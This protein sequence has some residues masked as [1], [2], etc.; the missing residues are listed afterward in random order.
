MTLVLSAG[1]AAIEV[2]CIIDPAEGGG[3]CAGLPVVAVLPRRSFMLA[4]RGL[5]GV[6]V[7]DTRAP[8]ASFDGLVASAAAHGLPPSSIVAPK[9]LGISLNPLAE[10]TPEEAVP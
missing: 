9:L 3:R 7:T 2:A 4:P 10:R 6:V 5:D 1:E 8:Q